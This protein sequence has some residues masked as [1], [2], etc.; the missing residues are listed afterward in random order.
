MFKLQ[1]M[2]HAVHVG[3]MGVYL[4]ALWKLLRHPQA[5]RSARF[6]AL[7]VLAYVVSPVDFIPDVVPVLGQLGPVR[8]LT[9]AIC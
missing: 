3:R 2:L 6:T 7:M 4:M 1:R 9:E 8:K 5:P